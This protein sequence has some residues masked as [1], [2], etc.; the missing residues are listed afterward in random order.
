MTK[1]LDNGGFLVNKQILILFN[2]KVF[3]G[4]LLLILLFSVTGGA[5][6]PA[7]NELMASW[8]IAFGDTV[9]EG[10]FTI[11]PN[12]MNY[13]SGTG[14]VRFPDEGIV[15]SPPTLK[16]QGQEILGQGVPNDMSNTIPVLGFYQS[17]S[18]DQGGRI[19]TYGDSNCIDR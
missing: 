12:D 1:I 18:T 5:N 3:F 14:I 13:A 11:G 9:L 15:I 6:V 8:G 10:D 4:K 16:D 17:K 7:L 2:E 19:V